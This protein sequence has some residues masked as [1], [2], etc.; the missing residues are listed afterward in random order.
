VGV[1]SERE[2]S[3]TAEVTW[4]AGKVENFL[5]S[6]STTTRSDRLLN[7]SSRSNVAAGAGGTLI[8]G[9]VLGGSVEREVLIRGV[10]P[11]LIASGVSDAL[12]DPQLDVYDIDGA[13]VATNDNWHTPAVAFAGQPV[14]GATDVAGDC[15]SGRCVRPHG[16]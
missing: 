1:I 10:G 11:G 4:S 5:G 13:V 8:T 3:L 12:T 15:Q 6:K 2:G 7:L 14:A 9:F 16:R